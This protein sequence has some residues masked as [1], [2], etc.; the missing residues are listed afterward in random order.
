[1]EFSVKFLSLK[2]SQTYLFKPNQT[3]LRAIV[4]SSCQFAAPTLKTEVPRQIAWK[5]GKWPLSKWPLIIIH[6]LS[7]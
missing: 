5:L 2:L 6:F 1:M 3:G 4:S 7:L